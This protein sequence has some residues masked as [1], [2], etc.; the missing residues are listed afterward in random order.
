MAA[1]TT[2][3]VLKFT[4]DRRQLQQ[5]L[6]AVRGDLSRL[7]QAEVSASQQSASTSARSEQKRLAETIKSANQ[8]LREEQRTAK[9]IA[10][11]TAE[12]ARQAAAQERV[13]ERAAKSLADVQI[14]EAKRAA[15]ELENSLKQSRGGGGG[16]AA[17]L[18]AVG[19][20]P[21]LSGLTS[22][23][24]SFTS[25]TE[26]AGASQASLAGP[27]GLAVAAA[28]AE[29]AIITKLSGALFDVA[30]RTADFEGRLFDMSQ[31]VGVSVE[32]LS[33][34]EVLA[35][36]TGGN[37][38]T[39]AASLAIFQ[40]NLEAAEDPTSKEAKLLRELGVTSTETEEALNQTIRALFEM[41]ESADQ[42]AAVLALFGR[43]GRFINAILKESG[44]DL[45]KAK[46]RFKELGIQIST[47]SAKA[48][49]DFND[50][51][52]VL[53][54]QLRGLT[55]EIGN[56]IIP[57][58]TSGLKQL[59]RI[60]SENKDGFQ[61][62]GFAA[63]GLTAVIGAPIVGAVQ[64][65]GFI[66][67]A[68]QPIIEAIADAYE[69]AA[70]AVQLLTN[71]IPEV[72]PNA[73]PQQ[74]L[75]RVDGLEILKEAQK[76]FLAS[77]KPFNLNDPELRKAILGDETKKAAATA[78]PG[79]ALLKQLQQELRTLTGVTKA[80]EV[81]ARLLDQEYKNLNPT[82]RAQLDLVAKTID[83]RRFAAELEKEAARLAAQR[84]QEIQAATDTLRQFLQQQGEALRQ[85]KF[86]DKT[87]IQQA[88]EF[89][90][91]FPKWTGVLDAST[92]ALIRLN[93]Q[94]LES[95]TRTQRMLDLLRETITA[96]P[97]PGGP[98]PLPTT[99]PIDIG[100][101]PEI[102]VWQEA[103]D[104][105][106]KR[107]ETF[108]T[109]V[110]S[111]FITSIHEIGDALAQGVASWA[112]YGGSFAKAMKQALAALGAKI[113]AEATMQAAIHA[114][115]AIGSLAFGN[116]GAAA[117]HAL[118]AAKFAAIAGVAAI[119]TRALAG[120][121]FNKNGNDNFGGNRSTTNSRLPSGQS[122]QPVNINRNSSV[123]GSSTMLQTLEFRV[124]GDAVIDH[125][126]RDYMLNGRTRVV[127][128][129]DGQ[130]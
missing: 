11:I 121:D 59:Q 32:T 116:F 114:A 40:K 128:R 72:D 26:A 65:L 16:G 58:L 122:V 88:E 35:T 70:A 119:A 67:K 36:T 28:A 14:R 45:E 127:I 110:R 124:K 1:R 60:V 129:S 120:N 37:I 104:A 74:P 91:L 13:R 77:L 4:G 117:Q 48:A 18:G 38:E 118:A 17:L 87:Q 63:A 55:A 19:R 99:I 5:V 52:G 73:I 31:Q 3:L 7:T 27:I 54:F 66:W 78:D 86:G 97:A 123:G 44:G 39:V 84:K 42:T 71:R 21:A 68:H 85:L 20:V 57:V 98:V 76:A 103:M 82:L 100:P 108:S 125:F 105:L 69:R 64:T 79:L 43:S 109:F 126:E 101:P 30:K 25:A 2:E 115:Y 112:L 8:R 107:M 49:D 102:S 56:Q 47:E 15:R 89:I 106:Q 23:L 95:A 9:E 61:A 92:E 22:E 62:L 130:G 81:A 80:Q 111:T 6:A 10:R 51:L 12:T 96:V 41:G 90:A 46:Q 75:G 53:Q 33:T 93:A 94:M 50:S 113:T 29:I 24:Q 34:L 83:Q